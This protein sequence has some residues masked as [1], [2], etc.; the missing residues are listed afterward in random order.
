M[1][2][3]C[4]HWYSLNLLPCLALGLFLL[5][6]WEGLPATSRLVAL[7]LCFLF[8]HQFEEYGFPGGS[9]WCRKNSTHNKNRPGP[10]S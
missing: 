1:K 9:P 8:L 5:F 4:R 6:R 10:F 3:Y 2:F 7:N